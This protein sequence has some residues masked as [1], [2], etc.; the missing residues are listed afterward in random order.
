MRLL[1]LLLGLA[2][3]GQAAVV[4]RIFGANQSEI[5]YASAG[6]GTHLY[7]SGTGIGSAFSPPTV[8]VGINADAEC[9][10]QVS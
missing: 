6:G 3:V 9:I 1:L 5:S 2:S 4:N 7:I 8:F 10:V